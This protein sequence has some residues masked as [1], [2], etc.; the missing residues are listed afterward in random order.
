MLTTE[1]TAKL[2]KIMKQGEDAQELMQRS[3]HGWTNYSD[4]EVQAKCDDATKALQDFLTE[5]TEK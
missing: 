5:I 3:F 1:Q 2:K 4:S